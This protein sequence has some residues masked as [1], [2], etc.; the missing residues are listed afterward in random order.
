MQ[1]IL[2][3]D[4]VGVGQKGSIKNVADGFALNKLFPQR[5]AVLA[6]PQRLKELKTEEKERSARSQKQE[7]EWESLA[8]QLKGAKVTVKARA[9]EYGHLYQQL[10]MLAISERLQKELGVSIPPSSI[11]VKE[12]IK[13][14]GRVDADIHLGEKTVTVAVFVEKA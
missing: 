9:N 10:G 6:T 5:L 2:L 11:S 13:S 7:A 4:V 8:R 3:K 12:P 1:V 14:V